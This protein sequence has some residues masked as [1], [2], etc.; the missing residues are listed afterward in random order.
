MSFE[1]TSS[2]DSFSSFKL[3]ISSDFKSQLILWANKFDI[4]CY[5]DSNSVEDKYGK[6][7][8][9]IG[10]DSVN[11]ISNIDVLQQNKFQFGYIKYKASDCFFFEP[12][13]IIYA[14]DNRIYINRNPL[15][16]LMMLDEILAINIKAYSI[17]KL[18]FEA[19]TSEYDYKKNIGKIQTD[20]RNGR[21]Y[22]LNYCIE[23]AAKNAELNPISTYIEINQIAL[24]P[25]SA[26][27]KN[28]DEWVLS[29]S[30][31]RLVAKRGDKL[32]AQPIK[33][34]ARRDLTNLEHDLQIK[35]ELK[36]SIKERAENTMI[37]DLI[38]HDMTPF[39]ETGSIQVTALCEVYTFPFVHQMI[40][41]IEAKL[42]NHNDGIS[43]L[44]KLLPAGSMTGAPKLEVMKAIDEIENFDR[45]IYAGNIGYVD[46]DGDMDFNVVIRTLIYDEKKSNL[47]LNVGGAITLLSNPEN[48][49]QEC[50]LKAEG[51]LKFFR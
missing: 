37:V 51:I 45:G 22:E 41:T 27:I 15:E 20:I 23:F 46:A 5:L 25:M 24:T 21:Y 3:P 31:E 19:K 50:L 18:N 39:A 14:I 47:K 13:Y 11:E 12:R 26:L 1:L 40:S 49:Y 7:D 34:T 44:K 42:A 4:F 10:I 17:T 16:S 48:E 36:S 38:R 30:P 35:N 28:K 2:Q 9:I 33:G 8:F 32:I 43:A 29:F 6:Y